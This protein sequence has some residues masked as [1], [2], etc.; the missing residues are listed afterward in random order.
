MSDLEGGGLLFTPPPC[1][2]LCWTNVEAGARPDRRVEHAGTPVLRGEKWGLNV[3]LPT[4]AAHASSTLR[5]WPSADD[6]VAFRFLVDE[7]ARHVNDLRVDARPPESTA[8][9]APSEASPTSLLRLFER[10]L[11]PEARHACERPKGDFVVQL[12]IHAATPVTEGA[13]CS[14]VLELRCALPLLTKEATLG[15]LA[16]AARGAGLAFRQGPG[17]CQWV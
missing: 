6:D 5:I 7:L 9:S 10:A 1:T 2:A 12:V 15:A 8:T 4:P 11:P 16:A 14:R 13:P 3:W 17:M